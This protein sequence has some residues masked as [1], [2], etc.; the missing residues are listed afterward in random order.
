MS[1]DVWVKL[2]KPPLAPSKL[3][4]TSFYGSKTPSMEK[5]SVATRIHNHFM[6]LVFHVAYKGQTT[7]DVLLG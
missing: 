1:Y 7:M 6:Q 2:G 4:F 5:L 3:E